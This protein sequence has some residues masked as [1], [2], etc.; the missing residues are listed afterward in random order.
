MY[1]YQATILKV[2][3]GDTVH[4]RVDLGFDTHVG[5]KLRL[6]G[7]NAPEM[8]TPEGL[9]AKDHLT[10]LLGQHGPTGQVPLVIR[11]EKDRTEKYGRYLATLL[12]PED[13]DL[14]RQMVVDGFAVVYTP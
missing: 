4:A 5:M 6:S 11:T 1:E 10:Q 7:I 14:N 9:P 8:K 2:V 3:D 13:V 12:L